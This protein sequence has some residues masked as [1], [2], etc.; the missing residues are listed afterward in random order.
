MPDPKFT[1]PWHG[2]PR[3]QIN[4]HPTVDSDACIGCGTCAT[5]C[6]RLVYRFDFEA[7]K[8]SVFDPLNCMVGCTTCANTCPTHA[9]SF[10]SLDSVMALEALPSVHHAIEDDLTARRDVLGLKRLV[11]SPDRV[12]Q[13]EV[14]R[15]DR[16]GPNNLVIELRPQGDD[17]LC[18]FIPGQYLELWIPESDFLSR[19]YSIASAP[20]EDGAVEVDLRRVPGG[21]FSEYAFEHM[22]V[23]DVLRGRGPL[24]TFSVTSASTTPLLFAARGT[25]FAPIKAMI[26]QQLALTPQRDIVLFWGT[27]DATD[28]YGLEALARWKQADP[29]FNA[30]LVARTIPST[31]VPPAGLV[32]EPGT[33]YE[34]IERT[35]L[36]LAG[37]DAYVAGPRKTTSL[38]VAALRARGVSSDK[39][40]VDAYGS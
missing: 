3:V 18:Q 29:S 17:C 22:K 19:A 34:A 33:V 20:R 1:K 10:P 39:I 9:I 4:W 12:V 36:N 6:S 35:T 28:F 32:V 15:V 24:G 13:L 11:P 21:R 37:R 23:G 26:V 38:A 16:P 40:K 27:T 7:K 25:G 8:A 5:G 14:T 31:F 30:V 2:I